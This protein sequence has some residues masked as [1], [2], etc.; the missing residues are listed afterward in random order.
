M[1]VAYQTTIIHR[2]PTAEHRSVV[3]KMHPIMSI[4]PC[5]EQGDTTTNVVREIV[6]STK[7]NRESESGQCTGITISLINRVV[8]IKYTV[9]KN[10]YTTNEGTNL[11]VLMYSAGK[12]DRRKPN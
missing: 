5:V 2:Y 10:V 4:H 7:R 1:Q 3:D 8:V 9:G 12:L 11:P 6:H